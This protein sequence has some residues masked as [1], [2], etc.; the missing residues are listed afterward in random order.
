MRDVRIDIALHH[1]RMKLG[2]VK[3]SVDRDP[4]V[5]EDWV[6]IA[7]P[8]DCLG[9][10][11]RGAAVT[12]NNPTSSPLLPFGNTPTGTYRVYVLT[13]QKD[14]DGY[15]VNPVLWLKPTGGD[16]MKAETDGKRSG[17]LIHGGK[18]NPA[19]TQWHG[20]RPTYGCVRMHDADIAQMLQLADLESKTDPPIISALVW[21]TDALPITLL[22]GVTVLSS[23]PSNNPSQA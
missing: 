11:D 15:G 1:D 19:Y 21:E 3:V 22:S 23:A 12:H 4:S 2:S 14:T 13:V 8:Y 16:A 20:L 7:G 18:V 5:N 10:S 6:P 17:L 9:I